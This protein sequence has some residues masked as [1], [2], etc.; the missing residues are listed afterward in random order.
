[1]SASQSKCLQ[2]LRWLPPEVSLTRAKNSKARPL[3]FSS[4]FPPVLPVHKG[5]SVPAKGSN[6]PLQ[7]TNVMPL[8]LTCPPECVPS[9]HISKRW[10]QRSNPRYP[11]GVLDLNPARRDPLLVLPIPLRTALPNL[12]PEPPTRPELSLH[13]IPHPGPPTQHVLNSS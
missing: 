1:M 10:A 8:V 2:P 7:A 5:S 9:A 11:Y 3:L 4:C 6:D 12:L 13:S